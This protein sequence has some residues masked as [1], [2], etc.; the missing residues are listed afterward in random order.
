[1]PFPSIVPEVRH[2]RSGSGMAT[3]V[4]PLQC[5]LSPSRNGVCGLIRMP[6]RTGC[7]WST[8]AWKPKNATAAGIDFASSSREPRLHCQGLQSATYLCLRPCHPPDAPIS[9]SPSEIHPPASSPRQSTRKPTTQS[10][11]ALPAMKASERS[12]LFL[13]VVLPHVHRRRQRSATQRHGPGSS[14]IQNPLFVQ[15]PT[16]L[17]LC[18]QWRRPRHHIRPGPLEHLDCVP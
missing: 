16:A 18:C 10:P 13:R 8:V 12:E 14:G 7:E 5:G 3:L 17:H 1:M 15:Y 4:I 9:I 11:S 6:L 2:P